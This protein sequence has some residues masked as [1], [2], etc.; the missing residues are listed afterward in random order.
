MIDNIQKKKLLLQS[1]F[2]H[3]FSTVPRQYFVTLCWR[4]LLSLQVT[5]CWLSVATFWRCC[6]VFRSFCSSNFLMINQISFHKSVHSSTVRPRGRNIFHGQKLFLP[7]GDLEFIGLSPTNGLCR[8][9]KIF[10]S[11]VMLDISRFRLLPG[12]R[13]TEVGGSPLAHTSCSLKFITYSLFSL[14]SL[15]S[16]SSGGSFLLSTCYLDDKVL[17]L[18]EWPL[19][20]PQRTRWLSTQSPPDRYFHLQGL[21]TVLLFDHRAAEDCTVQT[22]LAHHGGSERVLM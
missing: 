13:I 9:K 8:K 6:D 21:T 17:Y 2:N 18:W 15:S 14:L 19:R 5:N 7:F 10:E 4:L 1:S 12:T 3:Q 11:L 16:P 20:N 22:D